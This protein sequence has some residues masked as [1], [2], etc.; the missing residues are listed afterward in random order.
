MDRQIRISA[1]KTLRYEGGGLSEILAKI[2]RK[3]LSGRLTINLSQGGIGSLEWTSAK[4][5]K[6]ENCVDNL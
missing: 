5:E 4:Y 1:M 3:R 6:I 2:I